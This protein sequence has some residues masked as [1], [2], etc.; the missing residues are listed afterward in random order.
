MVRFWIV[1]GICAGM[2]FAMYFIGT[3]AAAAK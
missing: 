2:G 1:T 3:V